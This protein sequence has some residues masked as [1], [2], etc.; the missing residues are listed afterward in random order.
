M[1]PDP[2]SGVSKIV[3]PAAPAPAR[4]QAAAAAAEA[5]PA[6]P[7]DASWVAKVGDVLGSARDAVTGPTMAAIAAAAVSP[8]SGIGGLIAQAVRI[9]SKADQVKTEAFLEANLAKFTPAGQAA[10]KT[11]KAQGRLE[12]VDPGWQTLRDNLDGFLKGRGDVAVAETALAQLANPEGTITQAREHACVAATFQLAI[13]RDNPAQYF[14][15]ATDLASKGVAKLPGGE[16]IRVS[17][18]DRAWIDAQRLPPGERL[19]AV[20]QAALMDFASGG[21]YDI[22]TDLVTSTDEENV[23][24][25]MHGLKPAQARKL[26]DALLQVPILEGPGF[27]SRIAA[28]V[29][30]GSTSAEAASESLTDAFTEAGEAGHGGV[31]VV[32]SAGSEEIH[33]PPLLRRVL[34]EEDWRIPRF[35]MVLVKGLADGRVTFV[36]PTGQTRTEKLEGFAKR[37]C[38]DESVYVGAGGSYGTGGS[39]T[40]GRGGR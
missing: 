30:Y 6:S 29:G 8:L 3:P 1:A 37:I 33:L 32:V 38:L 39:S 7:A 31:M 27:F 14:Q 21:G 28:L 36:D 23:T 22:A 15:M 13:A 20:F 19:N 18:R 4:P 2:I 10:L 34:P 26:N 12:L 16:V 35:H 17:A 25:T 11:L 24:T 5:A 40:G 9:W